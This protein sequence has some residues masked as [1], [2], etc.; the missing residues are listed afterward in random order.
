[1]TQCNGTKST[2]S[3]LNDSEISTCHPPLPATYSLKGLQQG[4]YPDSKTRQQPSLSRV[5]STP[6]C[7]RKLL[8]S[9]LSTETGYPDVFKC[10]S[11]IPPR[12][13]HD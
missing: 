4:P 8:D 7:I 3:E 6:A 2:Q 1:M 10:L 13:W 9:S 5:V 12:K 11:S